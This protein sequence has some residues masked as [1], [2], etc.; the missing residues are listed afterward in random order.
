M[1]T[2]NATMIGMI[3][4]M[5]KDYNEYSELVALCYAKKKDGE[6]VDEGT[7]QWN[8]GHL[9]CIEEYLTDL[10]KEIGVELSFECGMH[11]FGFDDWQRWLEYVTV[12]RV[13]NL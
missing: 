9:Y 10:A 11:K 6:K 7:I 2:K 4:A 5:I 13:K 3:D 1:K 8:R 12:R